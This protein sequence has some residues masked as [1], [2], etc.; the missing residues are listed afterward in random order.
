L[1]IAARVSSDFFLHEGTLQS[2]AEALGIDTSSWVIRI[3]GLT[4]SLPFELAIHRGTAGSG[5]EEA[6]PQ[7]WTIDI[8]VWISKS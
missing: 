1:S 2:P 7:L 3:P 5:A 4:Q 8:E 6:A